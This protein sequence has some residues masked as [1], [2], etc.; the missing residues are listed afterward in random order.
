MSGSVVLRWSA[1]VAAL[2]AVVALVVGASAGEVVAHQA[3]GTTSSVAP[4]GHGWL[5]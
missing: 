3:D 2:A 4:D 1:G 5:D